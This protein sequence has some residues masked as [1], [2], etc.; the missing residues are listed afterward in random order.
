MLSSKKPYNQRKPVSKSQ[1]RN[2][3]KMRLTGFHLNKEGFTK[4]ELKIIDNIRLQIND[5]LCHWDI[6]TEIYLGKKLKP[7]KCSFCSKRSNKEYIRFYFGENMNYC[8]KHY[9]EFNVE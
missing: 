5:L 9:E 8:K 3:N 4:E 2:F 1:I 6:Q 7:F